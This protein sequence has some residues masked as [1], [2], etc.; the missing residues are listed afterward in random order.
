MT[1]SGIPPCP[2]CSAPAHRE[3]RWPS[4]THRSRRAHR[5]P[6]PRWI[7]AESS[8]PPL[9]SV[10]HPRRPVSRRAGYAAR[11]PSSTSFVGVGRRWVCRIH[12]GAASP[13]DPT[14]GVDSGANTVGFDCS[15][16]TQFSFAGVGVLIPKYSG[17]QYDTGRKVPRISGQA[18]RP[19]VLGPGRQPARRD[20][21]GRRA[22]AGSLR[23][24]GQSHRQP[25]PAFAASS[26]TWRELSKPEPHLSKG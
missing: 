5:P 4:P 26:P 15:G 1:G 8:C 9:D 13:A 11:R 19:V 2:S 12:G 22:D 7:S 3:T 20:L 24:C 16:L 17:D 21:P 18:R 10:P 6:R 25:G 23:Q 14:T